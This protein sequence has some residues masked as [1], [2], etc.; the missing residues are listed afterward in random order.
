V[1]FL[2]SSYA[3][4][5]R[6]YVLDHTEFSYGTKLICNLTLAVKEALAGMSVDVIQQLAN[7]IKILLDS[8]NELE[9][10]VDRS[11]NHQKINSNL[12]TF[13]SPLLTFINKPKDPIFL[14]LILISAQH[15][16]LNRTYAPFLVYSAC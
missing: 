7:G 8:S 15:Q 10:K 1:F 14:S 3:P 12:S 11:V 5:L 4:T 6:S 13:L 9:D 16:K 2:F